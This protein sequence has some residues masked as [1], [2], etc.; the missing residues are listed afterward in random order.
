MRFCPGCGACLEPER[1]A[2]GWHTVR[3]G[4]TTWRV[5]EWKGGQQTGRLTAAFTEVWVAGAVRDA[6]NLFYRS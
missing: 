5:A 2:D 3:M 1:M 4:D 6:L